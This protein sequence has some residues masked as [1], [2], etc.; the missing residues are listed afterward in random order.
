MARKPAVPEK[1]YG[2]R[3]TAVNASGRRDLPDRPPTVRTG[4]QASA[5]RWASTRQDGNPVQARTR[6]VR[7][8]LIDSTALP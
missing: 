7:Q 6:F 8:T 5:R 4:P 1:V 3:R 2:H